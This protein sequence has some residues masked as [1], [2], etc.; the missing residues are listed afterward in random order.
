MSR[1]F[2]YAIHFG[3][4]AFWLFFLYF[5][6]HAYGGSFAAWIWVAAALVLWSLDAARMAAAREP[7]RVTFFWWLGT[8]VAPFVAGYRAYRAITVVAPEEPAEVDAVS[9]D[10]LRRR[11]SVAEST[12]AAL[13]S[14]LAELRALVGGAA[15]APSPAPTPAQPRAAAPVPTLRPVVATPPP[16]PPPAEPPRPPV[17]AEPSFWD[18]DV[19]LS[20]LIGPKAFAIAGGI[21]TLLGVVFFFVLAANRGWIGPDLRVALGAAASA[22][23]FAGGFWLRRRDRDSYS[24]RAAVGAGI[25]GGYVTLAAATVLYGLLPSAVALPFAA[26]LAAVGVAV[27]IAWSAQLVAGLGL[28]GAIAAPALLALDEG[29][30]ASGTAFVAIMFAAAIVVAVRQVWAELLLASAV[31][32][33]PQAL[34]LA[35]AAEGTDWGAVVVCVAFVLLLLSVGVAYEF[36]RDLPYHVS[37]V[38]YVLA[39][40]TLAGVSARLLFDSGGELGTALLV[41][42][43]GY[44]AV[45]VGLFVRGGLVDFSSLLGALA[46]TFAAVAAAELLSGQSLAIAWALQAA[47][48]AW[49]AR[50]INEPRYQLG[51]LAYVGLSLG[52]VLAIDAPLTDLFT[53]NAHPAAGVPS[54][55]ALAAA[56]AVVAWFAYQWE[57]E[58][59]ERRLAALDR[60]VRASQEAIRLVSGSAAAL[61]GMYAVSLGILEVAQLFASQEAGEIRTAFEW[62]HVAVTSI[63]ALVAF[64]VFL[65]AARADSVTLRVGVAAGLAL[66]L[67][68]HLFFDI[69]TVEASRAGWAA[70][71]LG[72][73][74]FAVSVLVHHLPPR[75]A[76]LDP[77]ALLGAPIAAELGAYSAIALLDG[78]W[79]AVDL[80]GLGLLGVAV[81]F[82]LAGAAELSRRRDYA[83]VHFTL[84]LIIVGIAVT[85]LLDGTW[86]VLAFSALGAGLAGLT[87]VSSESRFLVGGHAYAALAVVHALAFEGTAADLFVSGRNPGDGVPAVLLASLAVLA[88]A[89][90]ARREDRY[91]STDERPL[92]A[93]VRNALPT[94]QAAGLW[95]AGALGVFTLSLALLQL[96]QWIS[97][98]GVDTDFKRGHVTV[99]ASW[100]IV[101]LLLLYVGLR[102]ESNRLRFAGVGLFGISLAKLFLYDLT[103]LT[104]ITRALSFLA[105]GALMLLAG[106]F[107]QQLVRPRDTGPA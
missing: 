8:F 16:S 68:K 39:S 29:I 23:V 6:V 64:A 80:Q 71:A 78:T 66:V 13:Q 26:G 57:G 35:L 100:A 90:V 17:P 101:G 72:A 65:L 9:D 32:A 41:V 69:D 19:D 50:A 49:L 107:Y 38:G 104:Q 28:I 98:G 40:A 56:I 84:A 34:W 88:V 45:A 95:I 87:I 18:R 44:G 92:P 42:A 102:N 61:L 33:V 10:E 79:G 27:A 99:S 21:V 51:A 63:A 1:G 7:W 22:A 89:L 60:T 94:I 11:L 53:A 20:A 85:I 81:P 93:A 83:S 24:A 52:H 5:F 62:G 14:E 59:R 30:S 103:F 74:V 96:T 2:A 37:G 82:A 15:P 77:V 76:Q 75:A 70:L 105:V 47:V 86:L 36:R 43:L 3:L 67:I 4:G 46:L 91:G 54:A 25:A 12:L 48:L 31:A 73:V 58:M 55:L 97:P 106:F